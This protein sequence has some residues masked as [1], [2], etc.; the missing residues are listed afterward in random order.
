MKRSAGILVVLA[1]AACFQLP[2]FGQKSMTAE[3]Q[4][5]QRVRLGTTEVALDVVV[6]D[7]KGRPVRDLK[8][9]DFEI[10]EDGVRQR[11]ESFR[12]VV[13]EPE[14]APA[15]IKSGV[16][17]EEPATRQP[18]SRDPFAEASFIAMVFDR[19]S[20]D[21]RNLA[22]KAPLN[23]AEESVKPDDLVGVFAI[24]LSLRTLQVYTSNAE[25]VRQA[26]DRAA[27][28][29]TSTYASSAEQVRML[30]D[31]QSALQNA[32]DASEATAAAG[33]RG[34]GDA[35]NAAGATTGVGMAKQALNQNDDDHVGGG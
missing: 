6:R 28:L 27:S 16:K 19:L 17:R 4:D 7:K 11:I 3:S 10:C 15:E 35:A 32:T 5:E 12:L 30:S 14:K 29:S 23:Y 25:L 9:S 8:E 24:D 33:G 31:R 22:H 2:A 13:H 1:L 20:P 18:S 26:I 34:T 21:A